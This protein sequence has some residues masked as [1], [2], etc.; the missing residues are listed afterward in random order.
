MCRVD[1]VARRGVSF[2]SLGNIFVGNLYGAVHCFRRGVPTWFE[3]EWVGKGTIKFIL[4]F[5]SE[6]Y[7]W[8][9]HSNDNDDERIPILVFP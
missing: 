9:V 7:R 4:A 6:G 2:S 1:P 3:R 5:I 8:D